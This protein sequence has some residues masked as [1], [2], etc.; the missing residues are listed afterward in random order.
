MRTSEKLV[1]EL[2]KVNRELRADLE[3]QA[4]ELLSAKTRVTV[5]VWQLLTCKMDDSQAQNTAQEDKHL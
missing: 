5:S 3:N 4:A 2:K 1:E